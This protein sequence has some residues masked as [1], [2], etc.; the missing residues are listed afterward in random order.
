MPD[1]RFRPHERIKDPGVF[2]RAFERKRSASDPELVVHGVENGLPH[3]RLGIS[4]GKKKVK[5][6][7]DRNRIKRVIR[8]AFRLTKQEWPGGIDYVIV[9]RNPALGF[10]HA[11]AVLPTLA[12][13]VARRLAGGPRSPSG[14]STTKPEPPR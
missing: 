9:P 5:S 1:S 13:A 10:G 3:A 4:V 7:V 12:R 2:R 6:A 11:S 8:E 14:E